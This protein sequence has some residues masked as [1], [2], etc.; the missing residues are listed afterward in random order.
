MA[1][2]RKLAKQVSK[3]GVIGSGVGTNNYELIKK[4]GSGAFGSAILYKRKLDDTLV[5]IKE[6]DMNG[7][8][9]REREQ[10]LQE[11]FLLSSLDH[12]HVISY[13]DSFHE[14][15]ILMIEMEYAEG[16]T[17][18]QYL[19][20]QDEYLDEKI[21]LYL[22]EQIMDG[23]T[24][25]HQ[26]DIL[27]RDL[28]TANIF[29]KMNDVKIG[30]FGISRIMG[31]DTKRDGG[32]NTV[33]GTPLYLSPEIACGCILYEM[34]CL[35]RTFE[36]SNLP[37]LV[38]HIMKADYK[39]VEGPYS[40]F[41]KLIIRDILKVEPA[42]RP[43]ASEL[44]NTLRKYNQASE[45]LGPKVGFSGFDKNYELIP[46]FTRPWS[47]LYRF[48]PKNISLY[49]LDILPQNQMRVSQIAISSTHKIVL[50]SDR[51]VLCMGE[52]RSG[53]LGLGDKMDRIEKCELVDFLLDKQIVKVAAGNGFSLFKSNQGV[54]YFSGKK[55]MSGA[56]R[57]TDDI[58]KPKLMECLLREDVIDIGCGHEH[59]VAVCAGGK[60]YVYGSIKNGRIGIRESSTIEVVMNDH[61]YIPTLLQLELPTGHQVTKVQC[62]IDATMLLTQLGAIFA[63]GDNSYNKLNINQRQG[64]F[65]AKRGDDKG[66]EVWKPTLLKTFE[67]RVVDV[68]LG[69]YHT[70]VI[71]ESGQMHIFGKNSSAGSIDNELFFWGS[72]GLMNSNECNGFQITDIDKPFIK[73]HNIAA[74]KEYIVTLPTLVLKLESFA[75]N[76]DSKPFIKLAGIYCNESE[77]IVQIDTAPPT[78]KILPNIRTALSETKKNAFVDIVKKRREDSRTNNSRKNSALNRQNVNGLKSADGSN[79]NTANTW[80]RNELDDA[81]II[82][83]PDS[84][85]S[86]ETKNIEKLTNQIELLKSDL[87][88]NTNS[89]IERKQKVLLKEKENE[90]AQL[91]KNSSRLDNSKVSTTPERID[92]PSNTKRNSTGE[93]KVPGVFEE[94]KATQK[95]TKICV[96]C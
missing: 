94:V 1:E 14:D 24:Y 3:D 90:L 32:A 55:E 63:M 75:S 50:T 16:G 53:Q 23:V 81:T 41:L 72:R 61:I 21:V 29:L 4:V 39:A 9:Q 93:D 15:G 59:A 34:A 30:D 28:K 45:D 49:F 47:A 7:I 8:S 13:Y 86:E 67:C 88:D 84:P 12:K 96:I 80:L 42:A 44:L 58:S 11:V 2:G 89:K 76:S 31:A 22:F 5:I 85:K 18:S 78:P 37:A 70:G 33:I 95:N 87:K 51:H 40:N 57:L 73:N 74:D 64:F 25:L 56:Q 66:N 48:D 54:V 91:A 77:V 46:R 38:N 68:T 83:F 36:A 92:S 17:L 20:L 60:V 6:I 71:L 69:K 27:H 79:L 62:G 26:H 35:Q 52:N 82:P 65:S 10:A 43:T 19:M